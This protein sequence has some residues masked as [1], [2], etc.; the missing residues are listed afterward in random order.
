M[1]AVVT[2]TYGASP[3]VRED[4]ADPAPGPGE[5]LLR[6]ASS[7]MN[8]FDLSVA[9]GMLQGRMEHQFPVI[10]GRDY[11]GTVEAVGEGTQR[12]APGDQVFGIVVRMVLGEGGFAEH[13]AVPEAMGA[14]RLPQGIPLAQAGALGL[15]GLVA[16][17]SIEAIDAPRG[18]TVLISGATGGVGSYATQIAAARGLHVIATARPGEAS[19]FVRDM[20]AADVVDYAGDVQTQVRTLRPGGVDAVLHFAGDGPALADLLVPGGQIISSVGLAAE[21]LAGKEV[22]LVV[23]MANPDEASLGRVAALVRNGELRIPITRTYAL[24]DAPRAFSEFGGLLGKAV[25]VIA[26]GS[27]RQRASTA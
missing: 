4:I 12:F 26:H 9:A 13:I 7:S 2:E 10:L 23:L 5:L 6:V 16:L 14:A 17:M 18:A 21:Q 3:V 15:A 20:G 27:Q 25:V 22:A 11:A 1:R 8:A 19:S 24:E